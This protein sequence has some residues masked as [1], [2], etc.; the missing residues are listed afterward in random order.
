MRKR[1]YTIPTVDGPQE[2]EC[3][4]VWLHFGD[5]VRAFA[6]QFQGDR[7]CILADYASGYRLTDLSGEYLR[8]YVANP[9]GFEE[10]FYTWRTLAQQWVDE[11]V[12]QKGLAEVVAK[13]DSVPKLN[14][15][16]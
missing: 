7:P 13:F 1:T 12:R 11:A 4:R 9:Y 3:C 15:V 6:L 5:G 16:A 2:R 10:G 8:R 14:E